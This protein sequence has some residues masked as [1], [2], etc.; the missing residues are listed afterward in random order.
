MTGDDLIMVTA[1]ELHEL[2]KRLE[3]TGMIDDHPRGLRIV[4]MIDGRRY[5]APLA[6]VRH[7]IDE[8]RRS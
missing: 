4:T 2:W 5:C 7:E 8:R 6:E 1:P 3:A